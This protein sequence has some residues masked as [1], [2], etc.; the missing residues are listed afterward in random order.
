MKRLKYY[1]PG[2]TLILAGIIIVAFP[3]ILI[4]LFSSIVIMAGIGALYFGKRLSE[5]E[6]DFENRYKKG[7][8]DE[9]FQDDWS[10]KKPLFRHYRRWF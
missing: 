4:A 10:Y 8:E 3:E 1:I 2:S 7:F 9:Y 6:Q 5:S